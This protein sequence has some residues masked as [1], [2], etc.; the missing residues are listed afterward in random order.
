MCKRSFGRYLNLLK[1]VFVVR[2][3]FNTESVHERLRGANGVQRKE[4]ATFS[5]DHE[6]SV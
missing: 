5:G 4:S 1:S 6:L 3:A 2:M